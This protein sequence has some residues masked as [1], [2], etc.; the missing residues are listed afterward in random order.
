MATAIYAP[1]RRRPAG[2]AWDTGR[3]FVNPE[4]HIWTARDGR[5]ARFQSCHDTAAAAT[6]HRVE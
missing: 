4:A 6:A 5:L 3:A 1:T 2:R